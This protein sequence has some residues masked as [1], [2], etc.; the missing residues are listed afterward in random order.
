[1][2]TQTKAP[3]VS[4]ATRQLLKRA[5]EAG[6]SKQAMEILF[7][8]TKERVIKEVFEDALYQDRKRLLLELANLHDSGFTRFQR[9]WGARFWRVNEKEEIFDLRDGLRRIWERDATVSD[10]QLDRWAQWTPRGFNR[11]GYR[12]WYPS[13]PL[14]QLVPDYKSLHAQLVQGV[15]EHS[16]YFARCGNPGCPAP[17]FFAR[18]SDQKYCERGECTRYAQSRYALKWWGEHGPAWRTKQ[19]KGKPKRAAK[20]KFLRRAKR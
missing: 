15:L 5:C 17:Y 13:I 18:R 2:V 7:S 14:G 9:R 20:G 16:R 10:R 4:S 1:M 12:A 8:E 3:K 19:K 11:L 6:T